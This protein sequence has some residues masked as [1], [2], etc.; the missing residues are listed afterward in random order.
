MMVS[1]EENIDFKKVLY[2]KQ[3][4][5]ANQARAGWGY[6]VWTQPPTF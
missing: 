2:W 4:S 1:S 5:V 6:R 3:S